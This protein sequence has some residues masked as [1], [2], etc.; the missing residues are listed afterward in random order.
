MDRTSILLFSKFGN[1]AWLNRHRLLVL[2]L[3]EALFALYILVPTV[4][5]FADVHPTRLPIAVPPTELGLSAE[6][7]SLKTIDN[8]KIA[9]WYIPSRNGAAIILLHGQNGNR[10]QML[11]Y[12]R[13]LAEHGFGVLLL[14]L[15]AH[16]DSEG[17]V[18]APCLSGLDTQAGASFLMG[19]R[20][21]QPKRIGV[22][23][24]STGAHVGICAAA[25]SQD[26]NAVLADG[27]GAGKSQDLLEPMLPQVQP[28]FFMA[29]LNW[30]FYQI[31]D[32][33]SGSTQEVPIKELVRQIPPRPILFISAGQDL[34]EAP[35]TQRYMEYAGTAATRW[36]IPEAY[37]CGG[38][39][40]RRDEYSE[41]M[42]SFFEQSLPGQERL[43]FEK[44]RP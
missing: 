3:V 19:R 17:D 44:P 20:E 34:L 40:I 23:G 9:G 36:V 33:F 39:A 30:M 2:A 35:L 27:V 16:G 26:I 15:R 4:A 24:I 29:P 6:Q 32:V 10:T 41:R 28:L 14:D 18:F 43:P 8:I 25:R 11:P 21:V 7:V 5:A 22:M 13:I 38:L 31:A 1:R 42:I 12:A 37:H